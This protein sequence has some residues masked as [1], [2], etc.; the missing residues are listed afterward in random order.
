MTPI[1]MRVQ[2]SYKNQYVNLN[3]V[4][5]RLE[6]RFKDKYE[7]KH[8]IKKAYETQHFPPKNSTLPAQLRSCK[9]FQRL[10]LTTV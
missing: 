1:I 9:S 2:Q 3:D 6:R 4:D 8:P 10:L 5:M 7:C